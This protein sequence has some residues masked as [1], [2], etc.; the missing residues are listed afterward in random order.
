[1]RGHAWN[2]SHR[3]AVDDALEAGADGVDVGAEVQLGE[4]ECEQRPAGNATSGSAMTPTRKP[5][6]TSRLRSS[7]V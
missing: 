2:P 5:D 7:T 3:H 1:M 4:Q 6:T